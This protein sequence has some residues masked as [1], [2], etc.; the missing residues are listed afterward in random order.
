[1]LRAHPDTYTA[2]TE[3]QAIASV[4]R[5]AGRIVESTI[6]GT[7]MAPTIPHGARI[8]I[9]P[10]HPAQLRVGQI[11]VC[12]GAHQLIAHRIVYC[13][14]GRSDAF[15]LTQG[16]GWLLCDPP[17]R[18]DAILG[19]VDEFSIDG[20]WKAPAQHASRSSWQQ[21]LAAGHLWLI[22]ACLAIHHG[23]ARYVSRASFVAR[24][25]LMRIRGR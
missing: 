15:V 20:V 24:T 18:K 1:M 9:C 16:D 2:V 21:A 4:L 6:N 22:E 5:K 8:R 3:F 17:T 23:L 11:G 10:R 19:V 25:T 12:V 13:G 14:G 7:S